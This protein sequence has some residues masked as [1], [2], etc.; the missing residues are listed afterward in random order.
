MQ[1][2]ADVRIL[3]PII[4][5]VGLGLGVLA[6]VLFS[7]KLLPSGMALALGLLTI[8]ASIFLLLSAARELR[9]A[10]TAFD[11]RKPTS[12]VVTTGPFAFTRN[13]IYLSMM[14]L[15]AGVAFVMNSPWT[16][17]LAIPTGS[18]LCVAVIKPEERYLEGKFGDTY[19]MYRGRVR[20]WI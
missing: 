20:R 1:D 18:I 13:P 10:K 19:R 2:K 6:G 17:L 7:A 16:L 9:S 15:Y 4:L 14:L 5:L 11:V 12:A 3:P 8:A